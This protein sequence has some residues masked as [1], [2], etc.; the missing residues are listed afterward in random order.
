MPWNGFWV[1]KSGYQISSNDCQCKSSGKMQ[2][3]IKDAHQKRPGVILRGQEIYEAIARAQHQEDVGWLEKYRGSLAE[4]QNHVVLVI[5][6]KDWQAFK[7]A[8]R[9]LGGE[10]ED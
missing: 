2:Q 7:E 3:A 10:R 6:R 4:T 1:V 5:P 8:R 9:S